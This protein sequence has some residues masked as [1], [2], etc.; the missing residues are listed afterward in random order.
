MIE[1]QKESN[2]PF[3]LENQYK[4]RLYG[5][6]RTGLLKFLLSASHPLRITLTL[7]TFIHYCLEAEK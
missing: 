6:K 3:F 4:P 5:L 2:H 1:T 7:F